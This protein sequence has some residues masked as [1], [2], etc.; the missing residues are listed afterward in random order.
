M[1]H[2]PHPD[3]QSVDEAPQAATQAAL[4]RLEAALRET[5][6]RLDTFIERLSAPHPSA[7]RSDHPGR[8]PATTT[9]DPTIR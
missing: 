6:R 5:R 9:D 4:T 8:P 1:S 2:A 3:E 7:G